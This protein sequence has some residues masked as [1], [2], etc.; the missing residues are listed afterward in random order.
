M[1]VEEEIVPACTWFLRFTCNIY[2]CLWLPVVT[3]HGLD[4]LSPHS[5]FCLCPLLAETLC[6]F[7]RYIQYPQP[8]GLSN[9]M[10]QGHSLKT[11]RIHYELPLVSQTSHSPCVQISYS[12]TAYCIDS[13]SF[14]YSTPYAPLIT[15]TAVPPRSFVLLA[16]PGS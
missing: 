15:R 4:D 16:S 9:L 7:L 3:P 1:H 14:L 13:F 5:C 10:H 6:T 8:S 11:Y 2:N 12:L